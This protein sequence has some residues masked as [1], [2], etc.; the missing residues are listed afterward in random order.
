MLSR[1]D[2]TV[3]AAFVGV[4]VLVVAW[5]GQVLGKRFQRV[6][7][8]SRL[9]DAVQQV[10]FTIV[11]LLLAFT[12]SLAL[13]RFDARRTAVL[14]ES[15]AIATVIL[16]TE[17][18]D[19]RAATALRTSLGDYLAT[20]IGFLTT[21]EGDQERQSSS[22]RSEE[23]QRLIW[24]VA[25]ASTRHEDSVTKNLVLTST[26]QMFNAAN[27]E[28]AA[29]AAHIPDAIMLVLLAVVLAALAM[30]GFRA[31][32]RGEGSMAPTFL[33]AVLLAL[34]LATI[35]DL[36]RPQVGLTRVDLQ[37]LNDDQR[38]LTQEGVKP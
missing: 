30:L 32:R 4:L 10:T 35:I 26:N 20:R 9:S 2:P 12:F 1:L 5:L 19:S 37:A 8:D 18:L 6:S 14:N 33:L 34:V 16:R 23:L 22:E 24:H 21:H 17:L 3:L 11:G 28:A 31:G 36:D 15:N 7:S 29:A 25:T 27:Q 38:L 13:A